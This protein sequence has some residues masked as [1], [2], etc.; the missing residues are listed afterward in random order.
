MSWPASPRARPV[1]AVPGDRRVHDAW[2]ALRDGVVADAQ[3]RDDARA[4]AFDDDVRTP[5]E[6]EE[7]VTAARYP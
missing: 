2:I 1:L 6:L 3:S 7:G 4:K 5:R